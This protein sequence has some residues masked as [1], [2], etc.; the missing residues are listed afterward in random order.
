MNELEI[1][2]NQL[3][4]LQSSLE[5]LR[6]D[7]EAF[8]RAKGLDE[9]IV[10]AAN[11]VQKLD[12]D[13]QGI[14]E[15]IAEIRHKKAAALANISEAIE[16][17]TATVLTEGESYFDIE[18]GKV[19]IGWEIGGI[20][21][22]YNGL[23]GG[24]KVIFDAAI[25]KVLTSNQKDRVIIIEAAEVDEKNLIELLKKIPED[26]SEIQWIVNHWKDPNAEM[27]RFENNEWMV[28]SFPAEPDPLAND[29]Q[30]LMF[31]E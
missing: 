5:S 26:E 19:L 4:G 27:F 10:K 17:E 13:I 9:N 1:L 29:K 20:R 7:E 23:S 21:I 15:E 31:D 16:K 24:Q 30:K 6:K 18:N 2:K 22:P 11:E 14:K 3:A 28:F 25:S 12:T 8:L